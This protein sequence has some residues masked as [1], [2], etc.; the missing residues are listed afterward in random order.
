MKRENLPAKRLSLQLKLLATKIGV[1]MP[2]GCDK[3]SRLI[4]E[5]AQTELKFLR[6]RMFLRSS[7]RKNVEEKSMNGRKDSWGRFRPVKRYPDRRHRLP[8]ITKSGGFGS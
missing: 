4:I 8:S 6:L 1:L 3:R 5:S 2:S 7:S